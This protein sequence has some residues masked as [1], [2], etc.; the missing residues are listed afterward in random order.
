MT[1]FRLVAAGV[2]DVGR[3]RD[4][5]EDDFLD[6]ADRL[7]LVAVADGMGGH[8]AG[9]VASATAL[10]SLRAAVASGEQLREAIEGANEAVLEKS[11]SDH[12]LHGM[13][14]TL[15]AGMLGT[16]GSLTVGHVG[17]SRGYL[18]RNGEL[19]Q[20][21]DDHSLV[22]EMVRGGELTPEQAEVHPQRSIITR[23]LGIDPLVDVDLYPIELQPGDR[24]L[25]CSDGLTT[26]VRPEEIA[27]ILGREPDP[28]RAA[29]L[30]V[31]AANAAGGED[32]VTAV[33]VEA[34]EEPEDEAAA[35]PVFDDDHGGTDVGARPAKPRRRRGRTLLRVAMWALPILLVLGVAF[36]FVGWYARNTYYVGIDR[37]RVTVF[38]GIK[39]GLLIWDPTIERRTDLDPDELTQAQREDVQ[40]GKKFSSRGGA[41]AYVRQ[42]RQ[43]V[44]ERT[45]TTTVPTPTTAPPP[46]ATPPS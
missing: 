31:D 23:A 27:N 12:D 20:I 7:G 14:T 34:I 4:G 35:A 24:I 41:D 26:M 39:G 6:Q 9:E 30:L 28:R 32:N 22:E 18:M 10:E 36:G 8:R 37:G 1:R 38:Q 21:T 17:D 33:I 13:G 25:L 42:L 15:T 29:Q 44:D 3:V 43:G 45:T 5:N 40:D 11:E 46:P 16:D 19:R 2:T